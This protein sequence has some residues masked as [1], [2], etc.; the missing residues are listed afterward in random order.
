[1][2]VLVLKS[3]ALCYE[4]LRKQIHTCCRYSFGFGCNIFKLVWILYPLI[5][6]LTQGKYDDNL[7]LNSLKWGPKGLS[8]I[9]LLS[10]NYSITVKP[11]EEAAWPSGQGAG[12][13]IGR[14]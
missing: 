4:M 11:Q 8:S 12:L 9:S 10:W 1:M 2:A 3:K 14:S 6:N 13:E 5:I 7:G